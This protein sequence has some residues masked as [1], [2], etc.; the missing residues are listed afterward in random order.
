VGENKSIRNIRPEEPDRLVWD[1]ANPAKSLQD[2]RNLVEAEAQ[3]AIDWYW[4]AKR[5]KVILSQSIRFFALFLTAAGGLFPIILP[6]AKN[7]GY[8][9]AVDGGLF[10][11][12]F[13]GL[14][15]AL[16]GLDKA[17]GYSSGWT[18]YV[19]TATSMTKL[20]HEFRMDWVALSAVAG[21]PPTTEQRASMIQRAK[22]FV[23]TIQGMVAQETKDWATEFQSNMAQMEKDLKAQLDSLK[24]QV[25]Q[26]AKDKEAAAKP[27][28]IELTVTNADKTDSFSFDVVSE[29]Q[30]GKSADS[31]ANAK[32]WTRMNMIPGQYR[33]SINAKSKG[34]TIS[35]STIVDVKPGDTARPS[36]TLPM[37]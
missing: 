10:A 34:N 25:E 7:M 23:S 2:V 30:S 31:V 1:S 11:S 13:I 14:A 3:K 20:L 5:S 21:E 17:F 28:A 19:L 18:R 24:V 6:I 15:A 37:A 8:A 12:L 27:G 35:A 4:D 26:G 32:V 16:L 29:G 33:I 9:Q 36:V 22:D